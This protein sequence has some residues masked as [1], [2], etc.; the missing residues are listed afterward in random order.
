[1]VELLRAGIGRPE[2]RE[3]LLWNK[4][5]LYGEAI[6]LSSILSQG[7]NALVFSERA[8][9]RAF[10]DLMGTARLQRKSATQPLLEQRERLIRQLTRLRGADPAQAQRLLEELQHVRIELRADEPRIAAVN[11]TLPSVRD[12]LSAIPPKTGVV[13]FFL[14]PGTHLAVFVLTGNGIAA[15]N[16]SDLGGFG[17]AAKIDQFRAELTQ[18]VEGVPTGRELFSALF[19]SVWESLAPLERLLIVPHRELHYMPFGATWF[20]NTGAGPERVY[21]C[22]RFTLG[23]LPSAAFLPICLRLP[24]R[25]L[26]GGNAVVLGNPTGDLKD[27]EREARLVAAHLGVAPLVRHQA[28]RAALLEAPPTLSAIH[29]ASHG[30][31]NELDPLLSGVVMADGIVTAEDLLESQLGAGLLALSG[32]V[33]GLAKRRPGDELVGLTRAAAAAGIPSVITSLWEVW[34]DSTRALF[35]RVYHGRKEGLPKDL[36]LVQAQRSLMEREEFAH[37]GHWAPFVLFGDW[38]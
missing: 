8:R 5:D 21:L 17:L 31:Y 6:V 3:Q 7:F 18:G 30:E 16:I 34:D 25:A 1:V 22:Q 32:C 2:D 4:E 26:G 38:R 29:V 13:E 15:L 14:G 19:A 35:D 33:T 37:P 10:L 11:D 27:A 9:A 12:I 23:L 36:A 24:R 28:T 20:P